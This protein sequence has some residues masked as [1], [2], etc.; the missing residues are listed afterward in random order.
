MVKL[1]HIFLFSIVII[2]LL[3]F[4]L[5]RLLFLINK[6]NE[7]VKLK[8]TFRKISSRIFITEKED[9]LFPELSVHKNG[10]NRKYN[11]NGVSLAFEAGGRRSYTGFIGFIRGLYKININNSN[12]FE[13]SQFVSTVSGSSWLMGTYLF[14][15][16][17]ID[18]RLLLG[19]YIHPN[20][21]NM[22]SLKNINFEDENNNYFLGSRLVNCNIKKY[23]E[24]GYK[25]GIR[26]EYIWNYGV[27]KVFLSYYG[28]DNKIISLN[29]SDSD[30]IHKITGIKP[31]TP[32]EKLPFWIANCALLN[33]KNNKIRGTTL[34]QV[35]PIYSGIPNIICNRD[36]PFGFDNT[37][38]D[39]CVGGYF[40][41]TY[42]LGSMNPN[43][44]YN[45]NNFQQGPKTLK[46]EI[47]LYQNN[48][49]T[50]ENVMGTSG[51]SNAPKFSYIAD[52]V[53]PSFNLWSPSPNTNTF[54]PIGDGAYCD[55]TGIVALLSRNVKH[56]ISII[57]CGTDIKND[58]TPE[59]YGD[60]CG[61]NILNLFG[62][63]NDDICS[64]E[65]PPYLYQSNKSQ[66][67]KKSD[68]IYFA[69]NILDTKALG[70]PVFSRNT[71][72]V[73]PNDLLSVKGGYYVDILVIVVQSSSIYNNLLPK[74]ITDTFSDLNGPFPNFPNY[75]MTN[76]NFDRLISIE[77]HQIN[78]LDSYIEWCTFFPSL[79]ANI[80]DMFGR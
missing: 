73:L 25:K 10:L 16:K 6:Y 80:I 28:L 47:P 20:N 27:G 4:V 40:Q 60:F 21:I 36:N 78:L 24:E 55:W 34:F 54:S 49:F 30:Y 67:F 70:G 18:S 26:P 58:A 69:K 32:N 66:V 19:K 52:N 51:S 13:S 65:A 41:Y 50:L 42:S 79:K 72:F 56:I 62:L 14:A 57:S 43:I 35:T 31:I 3:I 7:T 11:P 45:D 15:N 12:A 46:L 23:V 77:K 5:T 68:W 44:S 39:A 9:K 53:I 76:T 17:N 75:A 71:F 61:L 48:L 59:S 37:S 63:N 64:K 22:N 1:Y 38:D 33:L 29:E 2:I 8:K 74:S